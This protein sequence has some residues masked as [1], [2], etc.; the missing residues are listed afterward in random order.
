MNIELQ[1]MRILLAR[2]LGLLNDEYLASEFYLIPFLLQGWN[3]VTSI[4]LS[5][6]PS[7]SPPR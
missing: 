2:S 7:T 5:V 3:V 4:A 6:G 1:N